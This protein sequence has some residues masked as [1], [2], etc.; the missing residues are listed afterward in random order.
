MIK[1]LK[2]YVFVKMT[3]ITQIRCIFWFLVVTLQLATL[4]NTKR[5]Y[6]ITV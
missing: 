1:N 2:L 6:I 5:S 3:I 4:L